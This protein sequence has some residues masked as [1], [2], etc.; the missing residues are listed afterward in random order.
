M[1][2]RLMEIITGRK[3]GQEVGHVLIGIAV[4]A[5]SVDGGS[6]RGKVSLVV[7]CIPTV[8]GLWWRRSLHLTTTFTFACTHTPKMIRT[9]SQQKNIKK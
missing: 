2:G 1:T 5:I 7:V 9:C 8:L 6:S 4:I 3:I